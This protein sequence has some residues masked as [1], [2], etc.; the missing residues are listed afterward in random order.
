MTEKSIEKNYT[1]AFAT[2]VLLGCL[3]FASIGSG[4]Y[5]IATEPPPA[6]KQASAPLFLFFTGFLGLAGAYGTL[7][8]YQSRREDEIHTARLARWSKEG[9][10][11]PNTQ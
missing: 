4:I 7:G 5:K 8:S 6:P 1:K 11:H 3:G 2:A 9:Y 10:P